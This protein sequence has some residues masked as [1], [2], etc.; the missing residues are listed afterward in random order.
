[1]N[2]LAVEDGISVTGIPDVSIYKASEYQVPKQVFYDNGI[3][4]ISQGLK[5]L[6]LENQKLK[7]M[8]NPFPLD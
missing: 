8:E 7:W 1:M 6:S 5:T 3:V 2:S 4:I